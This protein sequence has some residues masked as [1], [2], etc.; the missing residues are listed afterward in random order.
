[1]PLVVVVVPSLM[2]KRGCTC[3]NN[4][5]K[6]LNRTLFTVRATEAKRSSLGFGSGVGPGGIG[7]GGG[8]GGKA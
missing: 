7:G 4:R 3:K 6:E 8:P 1:M 2:R 5:S